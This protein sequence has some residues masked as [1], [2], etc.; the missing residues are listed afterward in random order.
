MS[1]PTDHVIA[2]APGHSL[3]YMLPVRRP[4]VNLA[5][6]YVCGCGDVGEI[7][8]ST[9]HAGKEYDGHVRAEAQ[10]QAA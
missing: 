2:A 1:K 7:Q 8:K 4:R 3:R 5:W 9:H 10:K 6:R